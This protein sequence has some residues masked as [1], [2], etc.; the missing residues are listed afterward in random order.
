MLQAACPRKPQVGCRVWWQLIQMGISMML[1]SS[2][3]VELLCN[4]ATKC[5]RY[6]PG[7]GSLNSD[8]LL[9][10][11]CASC[12]GLGRVCRRHGCFKAFLY[13]AF[14]GNDVKFPSLPVQSFITN[15]YVCYTMVVVYIM[16]L[17]AT[18]SGLQ[19]E[20]VL[21]CMLWYY[22]KYFC[23]LIYCVMN[24]TRKLF[25]CLPDELGC[26]SSRETM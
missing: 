10:A 13:L 7:Q 4:K 18:S 22:Y 17:Y 21:F 25:A 1:L 2:N 3:C 9:S 6:S 16:C 12:I 11:S 19:N 24:V 8:S 20:P 26:H 5:L 15:L 23:V 14:R